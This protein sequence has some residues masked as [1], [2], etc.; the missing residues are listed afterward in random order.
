MALKTGDRLGPYEVL[1]PLGQGGMG[2]VYKARDQRLGRDVAIKTLSR[3][4]ANDPAALSRFERESRAVAALSHPNI[5]AVYDV[6]THDGAPF[7]VLELLEG[8][9]L[10]AT[11]AAGAMPPATVEAYAEQVARGL[12]AAHEKGIVHRDLKPENLFLTTQGLIKI[13]DFGLAKQGGSGDD[14]TELMATTPGTVMGTVGYMSPEQARGLE[15]DGRG[16][17]FSMGAVLYEMLTGR[18]AFSAETATDVLAAIVR[19]DPADVGTVRPATPPHLAAIVTRCLAKD[20]AARFQTSRDLVSAFAGAPSSR[21]APSTGVAPASSGEQASIAV[22]PFEDIS[23]DRDNEFFVD[24]LTDEVI[25]DLSKLSGL[26]VI[27]RTSA[28]QLKG[29]ERDLATISRDLNVK[30]VLEGSVRKAGQRLRIT[31]QLVDATSDAHLWSEKYNGTLDDIFDIQEQVARAIASELRVKL[32]AEESKDMAARALTDPR[33][34]EGYLRARGELLRFTAYGLDRALSDID[35]ALELV[36]DNVLLLALEGDVY[37]QQT[38]LGQTSE[39]E[40]VEKVEQI[41]RRIQALEPDAEA[42]DRLFGVTAVHRGR[43]EEGWRHL[44]RAV[45]RDAPDP[46][47]ATL[48]VMLASLVGKPEQA[49][50]VAR[51]LLDLD[52]LQAITHVACGLLEYLCRNF[53]ASLPFLARGYELDPFN[54]IGSYVYAQA[55]AAVGRTAEAIG[56]GERIARERPAEQ[57]TW[58]SELFTWALKNDR[59]AI[60]LSFTPERRAWIRMDL[61]Y[62]LLVAECYAMVGDRDQAFDWLGHAVDYGLVNHTFLA[63]RDPFLANLR[64]DARFAPLMDRARSAWVRL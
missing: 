14:E 56:V 8:E 33:A 42:A 43:Y 46:F 31:V 21:A 53:E 32:T 45:A 22:L 18:R 63:A 20:P 17:V 34:Y 9:T 62:S 36:G 5:L 12:V 39:I 6:G 64:D 28:R 35:H 59:D 27:S 15:A 25:S 40:Q 3:H 61:Q 51:R 49:E 26:R 48:F 11:M 58:L 52:P 23:P 29:R 1:S 10:R 55:L 16:D 37:W 38:N 24:G 2:E 4:L 50:P 54:G 44:S 13:L 41:A 47:T 60:H 19:D 30:Y 7:V 57:W